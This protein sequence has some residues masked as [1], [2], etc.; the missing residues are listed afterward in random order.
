MSMETLKGIRDAEKKAQ[1]LIEN[2]KK[3]AEITL[4]QTTNKAKDVLATANE[5]SK[6]IRKEIL[7]NAQ[8]DAID[9]TQA[10]ET[11]HEAEVSEHKQRVEKCLS[12]CISGTGKNR[13]SLMTS[14]RRDSG[15]GKK[16]AN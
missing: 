11:K 9:E 6:K 14:T 12:G 2:A 13:V 3:D 16:P 15:T 4:A 7:D 1:E 8:K 10:L 5:E